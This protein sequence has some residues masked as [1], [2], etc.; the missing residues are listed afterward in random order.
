MQKLSQIRSLFENHLQVYRQQREPRNLYDP[1]SYI[2][3]LGGKR[4]RPLLC[5][6]SYLVFRRDVTASLLD[7]C[8]AL[9]VFH[10]F[11]LVH[12]DIMDEASLR[13]GAAT[14][15]TKWDIP[16]GILS[17]DIMLIESYRLLQE[18]CIP[19]NLA[20][21]F[22]VFNETATAVCEG[23]QL[24]MD[25]EKQRQVSW[26]SYLQMIRGK[27][28][29]LIGCSLELGAIAANQPEEISAQLYQMGINMGLAF[30]LKDDWLDVYGDHG[31][32]GKQIGGDILR[33]KKSAL[34]I[35]AMENVSA[36][37][38]HLLEQIYAGEA[39]IKDHEKIEVVKGLF[40]N[41]GAAD[42]V[43]QTVAAYEKEIGVF[44][45][46]LEGDGAGAGILYELLS[47]LRGRSS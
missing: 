28:A 11:S 10:N 12:D 46:S 22:K 25:F 19:Q 3:G 16:T 14:V 6:G 1:V 31:S 4:V 43:Q 2:M 26:A 13:R 9:E 18:A 47:E 32:V 27:T 5:A 7:F 8:L 36:T 42:L 41:S 38:R 37:E 29:S 33:N 20:R 44:L 40:T 24:D 23:Q 39:E 30:Q 17:G 21:A 34:Y 45:E 35:K 15:H